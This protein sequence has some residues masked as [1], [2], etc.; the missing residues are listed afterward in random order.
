MPTHQLHHQQ[1]PLRICPD[2]IRQLRSHRHVRR[3]LPRPRPGRHSPLLLHYACQSGVSRFPRCRPAAPRLTPNTTIAEG[4]FV[5]ALTTTCAKL[6][7]AM[8]RTHWDSSIRPVKKITTDCGPYH[9]HRPTSSSFASASP[10]RHRSRTSARNGSPRSTTTALASP[11]SLSE[12]R[13]I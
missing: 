8:S 11:A 1:I 13:S 2:S 10:P 6:G 12:H 3:A 9:T 5:T 7:S 4:A